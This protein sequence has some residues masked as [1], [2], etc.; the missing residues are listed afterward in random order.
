MTQ[1]FEIKKGDNVLDLTIDFDADKDSPPKKDDSSPD[2]KGPPKN[3]G[4]GS[5]GKSGLPAQPK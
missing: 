2:K 4:K 3:E 1:E 5:D